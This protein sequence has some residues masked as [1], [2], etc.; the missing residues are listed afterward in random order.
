MILIEIPREVPEEIENWKSRALEITKDI[1]KAATL[2][3]KHILI[4][5]YKDH[6]RNDALIKFL[7]DI[8]FEKCWYTETKFGGDYQ[9]VEHYRPKKATKN[10]D[11]SGH[12]NHTGYYWLAFEIS[13]YRLCK[14]RPNRKKG[15]FFPIVNERCR[16]I[17]ASD[18]WQDEIPFFLDPLKSSDVL[19]LSFDDTGKPVPEDFIGDD[20]L[21]R[22]SFT[23]EKYYLDERVL[24]TRRQQKWLTV[25]EL[26]NS[27]L[28]AL[29]DANTT[30]SVA[31]REY[32]ESELKK[33]QALLRRDAEFSSVAKASLLKTGEPM[34]MKIA[35]SI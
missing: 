19:L 30:K 16:A 5:R 13:N 14:S 8:S 10:I 4:D 9:E 3:E 15:T 20:D 12:V 24:N 23:I 18:P 17:I 33:L 21:Q 26:Y 28:N 1:L 2:E 29:K 31:Q 27:Y 35:S 6:W 11:G 22:V 32:A 7:S 34:A 25:R